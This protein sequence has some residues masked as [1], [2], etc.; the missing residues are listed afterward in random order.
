MV[1]RDPTYADDLQSVT[2]R[3]H[4]GIVYQNPEI[5]LAFKAAHARPK[6]TADLEASLSKLT[7]AEK[8]WLAETVARLHRGHSWLNHF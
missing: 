7:S 3:A 4:D 2:W 6:D 8:A 5:T 1:Q